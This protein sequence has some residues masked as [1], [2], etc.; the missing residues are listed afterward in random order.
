MDPKI[1]ARLVAQIHR[2][3]P[4]FAGVQ[5]RLRQHSPAGEAGACLLTFQTTA[6]L[7]AGPGGKALTRILRVTASASG[8]IL[9]VSTSR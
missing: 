5:P 3:Y 7:P 6:R 9:K 1:L 2:Q 4:E 8:Q